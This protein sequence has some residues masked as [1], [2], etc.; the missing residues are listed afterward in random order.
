MAGCDMAGVSRREEYAEATQQ[1]I[2][3]AARQLF[4]GQGYFSTKVDE[5]AALVPVSPATV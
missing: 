4:S 2:V 1:A 3:E 5:I